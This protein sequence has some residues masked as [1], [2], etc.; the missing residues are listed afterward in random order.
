MGWRYRKSIK[1]APGV[2]LNLNKKSVGVRIGGKRGGI[3]INSKTGT[4]ARVSFPGTG[5]SYTQK[6]SEGKKKKRSK[7]SSNTSRSYTTVARSMSAKPPVQL[8]AWFMVLAI[9][10]IVIGVFDAIVAPAT[11]IGP[12]SF[13][14]LGF[15]YGDP[16]ASGN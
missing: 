3:N 2:R 9:L 4:T 14:V 5:L 16:T 15:W 6:I 8:R 10:L 7:S 11:G 12:A 13:L 1:I